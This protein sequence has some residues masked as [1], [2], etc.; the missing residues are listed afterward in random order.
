MKYTGSRWILAPISEGM[1]VGWDV[2]EVDAVDAAMGDIILTLYDGERLRS[3]WLGLGHDDPAV[4]RQAVANLR[5]LGISR[6]ILLRHG[7]KSYE[8]LAKWLDEHIQD[9]LVAG[10][11]SLM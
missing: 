1:P 7:L 3:C 8:S 11:S 5:V 9:K 4:R 10:T 2:L 6:G